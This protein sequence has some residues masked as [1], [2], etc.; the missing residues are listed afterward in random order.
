MYLIT[1][2]KTLIV[3]S[4]ARSFLNI[5]ATDIIHLHN[6]RLDGYRGDYDTFIRARQ[7]RLKNQQRAFEAQQLQRKHIQ[8]FIDRF[9]CKAKMAKMA[10]S[11]MKMLER[12]DVIT[13][14]IEDPSFSFRIPSPESVNHPYLQFVDLSF[15]WN[16]DPSKGPMSYLFRDLNFNI[17][18]DSRIALVGPNG[19]GKSFL[20]ELNSSLPFFLP[21]LIFPLISFFSSGKTTFLSVLF[22]ELELS[23]GSVIR[24]GKI[25]IA[26]FGQHHIEQLNLQQTALEYMHTKFPTA[27]IQ[28]LRGHLGSLGLSG[29]LALQPIYKLSGGQKSRI[30]LTFLRPHILLL[31]ERECIICM[32]PFMLVTQPLKCA[33]SLFFSIFLCSATNHL[34]INTV[35]ALI[36]AIN[37]YEGGVLIV[38]I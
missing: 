25:R 7:E 16:S 6:K 18:M 19:A 9:Q 28:Q 30:M 21:V 2:S 32:H 15:A 1:F 33:I 27:E 36:H 12:M 20:H 38:S 5:V 13:E 17:G 3:V 23:S 14:M 29:D 11:H 8:S 4:H 35:E 34:D 24:E 37:Q 10:Q 26:K 22:G 31:D